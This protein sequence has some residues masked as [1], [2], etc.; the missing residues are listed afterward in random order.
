MDHKEII[1]YW[2]TEAEE[3]L[4][5]AEHLFEKRDFSYSLFFGHLAVEKMYAA[6]YQNGTGKN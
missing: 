2:V 6:V 3:S 5:V 1:D 4:I